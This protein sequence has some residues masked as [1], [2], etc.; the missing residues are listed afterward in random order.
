MVRIVLLCL[1]L[2]SITAYGQSNIQV[3]DELNGIIISH[4]EQVKVATDGKNLT[5]MQWSSRNEPAPD[6]LIAF[7]ENGKAAAS[8][9]AS[10]T[11]SYT[12]TKEYLLATLTDG[13]TLVSNTAKSKEFSGYSNPLKLENI[14][15]SNGGKKRLLWKGEV[16]PLDH[17]FKSI[18]TPNEKIFIWYNTEKD[19]RMLSLEDGNVKTLA[20]GITALDIIYSNN[21]WKVTNEYLLACIKTAHVGLPYSFLLISLK[22]GL[23]VDEKRSANYFQ[24]GLVSDSLVYTLN[25]EKG[26]VYRYNFSQGSLM[27]TGS[28]NVNLGNLPVAYSSHG[29]PYNFAPLPGNK[30]LIYPTS[31]LRAYLPGIYN[32]AMLLYNLDANKLEKVWPNIMKGA[33]DKNANY[34][35]FKPKIITSQPT[36]EP[37]KK[38]NSDERCANNK[39]NQKWAIGTS[40]KKEKQ[41][42]III[43]FE[44]YDG[45][46]TVA[47]MTWNKIGKYWQTSTFEVGENSLLDR[48][49][50]STNKKFGLCRLCNATGVL[51]KKKIY[52]RESR[53]V[54]LNFTDYVR[55]P[56]Y[57]LHTW[58]KETCD[59][60]KGEA[61]LEVK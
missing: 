2:I 8:V 50:N 13:T 9:I 55:T 44:C 53:V 59:V 35:A 1:S 4:I 22:T 12:G 45:S 29:A 27:Q 6:F 32:P 47:D 41:K 56:T 18:I 33:E 51:N 19:T 17:K 11:P 61:W 49:G 23:V 40:F 58:E 31:P 14:Y 7:G 21:K 24:L 3:S 25:T 60:C 20:P 42:S 38:L 15:L 48:Y 52:T 30:L 54:L 39:Q 37:E 16:S 36:P 28:F 46:Y 34:I 10:E 43:F 26:D 57:E 5:F